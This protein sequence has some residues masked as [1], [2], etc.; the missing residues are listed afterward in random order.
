MRK[1]GCHDNIAGKLASAAICARTSN[2]PIEYGKAP[3]K[4]TSNIC[5]CKPSLPGQSS[6][7]LRTGPSRS[8]TRVPSSMAISR[9]HRPLSSDV[10]IVPFGA[11][12][13]RRPE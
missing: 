7:S 10:D 4:E 5:T 8:T 12:P 2:F 6:K 13:A 11:R 3:A 1:Q 9:V